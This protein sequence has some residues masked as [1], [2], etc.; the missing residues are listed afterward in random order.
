MAEA[1]NTTPSK[2]RATRAKSTSTGTS[3]TA[4]VSKPRASRASRAKTPVVEQ[5]VY[6]EQ[7]EQRAEEQQPVVSL[8]DKFVFMDKTLSILETGLKTGK[9]VILYGPGGHG[10]SELS[11]EFFY[12]QGINPYVL[13]MGKGLNTDRLFGGVD[14]LQLEATGKIEYL[15]E[16]S[17]MNHPFVIFE[18]MMDAPDHLLEELKDILSS[19]MFRNGTQVFPIRTQYI[20]ACTNKNRAEFSKN[21]SL[22]ALMERFPLELNVVWDNYT[23]VSYTTLLEGKFG[24]GRVDPIIPF[25]LSEYVKN[26]IIISP[27]TALDSYEIFEVCGPSALEFIADF[28]KK[29]AIIKDALKKFSATIEFKKLGV[30]INDLIESLTANDN[31]SNEKKANFVRDY[32]ELDKKLTTLKKTTVNDDLI[33]IHTSLITQTQD[34]ITAANSRFKNAKAGVEASSTDRSF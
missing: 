26:N 29:P 34:Y 12:E 15:V 23:E 10:K 1:K 8:M 21:D 25:I 28:A 6:E 19:G 32:L 31:R 9:N 20:V 24:K 30:E 2:P 5:P 27:R 16:N 22:K 17:F 4:K 7:M 13:T 14:I 3:P 33:I 18:E 11:L